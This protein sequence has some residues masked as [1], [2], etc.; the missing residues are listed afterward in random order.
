MLKQLYYLSILIKCALLHLTFPLSILII[1]IGM[2][3]TL[4]WEHFSSMIHEG[5]IGWIMVTAVRVWRPVCTAS[6]M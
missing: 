6:S 5:F 4:I 1:L 2:L 3:F